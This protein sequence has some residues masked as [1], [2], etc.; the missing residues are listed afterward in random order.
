MIPNFTK[1]IP[2]PPQFY[3]KKTSKISPPAIAYSVPQIE[4]AWLPVESSVTIAALKSTGFVV[5]SHL[6]NFARFVVSN[7]VHFEA[8]IRNS[9]SKTVK[10]LKLYKGL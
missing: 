7:R 6:V 10:T 1:Q 9:A 2:N 8:P 5:N 4:S 3:Q